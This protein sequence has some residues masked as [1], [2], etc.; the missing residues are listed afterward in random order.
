M[1]KSKSI[2]AR[3]V[4]NKS[5]AR[6]RIYRGDW[7]SRS[8]LALTGPMLFSRMVFIWLVISA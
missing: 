5:R 4:V 6:S 7:I 3:E 8:S 1:G 2:S